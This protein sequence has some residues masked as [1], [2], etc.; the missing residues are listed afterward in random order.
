MSTLRSTLRR[1]PDGTFHVSLEGA[2][3]ERSDFQSIFDPLE[4]DTT[5]NMR[6]VERVNS[7]GIHRWIPLISRLSEEKRVAIEEIPYPLVL[8]AN[9][10][11]NLFGQASLL[12]CLAPYYC[13][14]CG[15]SRTIV[16]SSD[17]VNATPGTP[18]KRCGTCQAVLS[19]D[20]LDSY[21]K[22]LRSRR[23]K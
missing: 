17:D 5:F 3:D 8:G 11:A 23:W 13:D 2:M 16:V 4:G 6:G 12:S 14:R 9:S 18:E 7:I 15:E 1:N 21:F 10:V 19:F 22:F 20:E